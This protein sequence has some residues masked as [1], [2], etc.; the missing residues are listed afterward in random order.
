MIFAVVFEFPKFNVLFTAITRS[1]FAEA[2]ATSGESIGQLHLF[3]L[4]Y[5]E[6]DGPLEDSDTGLEFSDPAL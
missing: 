6:T 2:W 1:S 4:T 5:A 3:F